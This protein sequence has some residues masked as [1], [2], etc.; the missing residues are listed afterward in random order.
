MRNNV[1]DLIPPDGARNRPY[2]TVVTS[3]VKVGA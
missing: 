1:R 2:G 3:N